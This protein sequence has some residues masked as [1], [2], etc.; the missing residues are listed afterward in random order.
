MPPVV[1]A[2][3]IR[4]LRARDGAIAWD[5]LLWDGE[6][7][8]ISTVLAGERIEYLEFE[9]LPAALAALKERNPR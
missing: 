1:L 3:R 4:Y 6:R 5:C 2:K 8:G 7:Q 9:T